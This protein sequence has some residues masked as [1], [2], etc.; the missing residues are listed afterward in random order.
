MTK[1]K[2]AQ[3]NGRGEIKIRQ[4]TMLYAC[5]RSTI[6][7]K[8]LSIDDQFEVGVET[9]WLQDGVTQWRT[10]AILAN[11]PASFAA[12]DIGRQRVMPRFSA[13]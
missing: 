7:S 3:R 1:C 5:I 11:S 12:D 13:G 9:G 8:I 6:F 2:F 10:Q 4:R